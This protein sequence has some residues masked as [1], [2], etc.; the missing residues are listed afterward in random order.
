[1]PV[2][3]QPASAELRAAL[4][5]Y[6]ASLADAPVRSLLLEYSHLPGRRGNLELA[7]RFAEEVAARAVGDP[8]PWWDLCGALASLSPHRA[9]SGDPGEFVAF[10]GT[11]GSA[12][13]ACVVEDR[14]EPAL[15][16]LRAA[17][18][19]PRWRMREATA[20]GL[21]RLLLARRAVALD[22]LRKLAQRGAPLELRAVVAALAEPAVL[23]VP[24]LADA[25]ASLHREVLSRFLASNQRG[26]A[27]RTL[28]QALGYTLSV[29]TVARPAAGFAMLEELVGSAD[30]DAHWIARE[31]LRKSRLLKRFPERTADLAAQLRSRS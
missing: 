23:A 4:D 8:A 1:M 31:N 15:E 29:I 17:A 19:D 21:Q 16:L 26:G 10:C 2:A 20:M 13:V 3:S 18:S 14:T 25:A 7:E 30:A 6:R 11:L 27:V 24:E 12:A 5:R 9:P 28:R 22:A